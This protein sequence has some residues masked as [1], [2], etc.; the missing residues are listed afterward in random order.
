MLGRVT[1]VEFLPFDCNFEDRSHD[2]GIT[3][4]LAALWCGVCLSVVMIAVYCCVVHIYTALRREGKK[5]R[6]DGDALPL[7]RIVALVVHFAWCLDIFGY[8]LKALHCEKLAEV[9]PDRTDAKYEV[10]DF[11]C[12]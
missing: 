10:L 9:K 7:I 8:R 1:G 5:S 6:Y 12:V 11:A 3:N 2:H 4:S